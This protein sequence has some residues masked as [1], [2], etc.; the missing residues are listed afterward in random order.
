MRKVS[1]NSI[2]LIR[3]EEYANWAR[4][5]TALNLF[6]ACATWTR[7]ITGMKEASFIVPRH[8]VRVMNAVISMSH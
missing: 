6:R 5:K 1:T 4:G 3:N 2:T 7:E 8:L